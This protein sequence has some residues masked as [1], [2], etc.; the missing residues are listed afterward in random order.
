MAKEKNVFV[1]TLRSIPEDPRGKAY[2]EKC[3]AIADAM[4]DEQVL[5]IFNRGCVEFGYKPLT[6]TEF[7]KRFRS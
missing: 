5:E 3:N 2:H 7:Q 1:S 6:M 4:S